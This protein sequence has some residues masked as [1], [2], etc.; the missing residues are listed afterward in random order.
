MLRLHYSEL[1][2]IIN[3]SIMYNLLPNCVWNMRWRAPDQEVDKED[4]E[5]G[6]AKRLPST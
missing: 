2:N 5:R 4:T 3:T 1:F 6:C